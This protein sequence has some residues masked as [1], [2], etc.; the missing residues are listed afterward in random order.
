MTGPD[1]LFDAAWAAFE[2]GAAPGRAAFSMV[3]AA[4]TDPNGRPEARTV[5]LRRA[6]R[7]QRRLAFYTDLRSTKIAALRASPRIVILGYDPA[8]GFQARAEGAALI[9]EDGAEKAAAW[10][11]VAAHSRLTY[12]HAHAPGAPVTSPE[13]GFSHRGGE[14][15]AFA[16]FAVVS[17]DVDALDILRLSEA[18]HRRAAFAWEGDRWSG[19]WIAP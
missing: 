3:A 18:G 12:R 7:G 4:T 16:R 8:A 2:A 9:Y 6:N 17:I 5:V 19:G 15:E 14:A 11:G 1:Q 13:D 10:R